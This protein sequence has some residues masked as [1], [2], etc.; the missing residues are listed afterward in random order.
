[1]TVLVT[2]LWI[3]SGNDIG[4]LI[5]R[6]CDVLAERQHRECKRNTD[7][8]KDDGIFGGGCCALVSPKA[9]RLGQILAF[10]KSRSVNVTPALAA[11]L[12]FMPARS[13]RK[14]TFNKVCQ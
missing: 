3:D 6:A 8:C 11:T 9:A 1:M 14:L 5:D 7:H 12:I 4:T 13:W 2:S 10:S